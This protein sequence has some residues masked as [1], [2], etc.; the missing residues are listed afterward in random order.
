MLV[1]FL[2][3]RAGLEGPY[4]WFTG[5]ERPVREQPID[6]AVLFNQALDSLFIEYDQELLAQIHPASDGADAWA[7]SFMATLTLEEKIG[8][9]F[10]TNLSSS[11]SDRA[12]RAALEAVQDNKVG[13]FLV[14]RAMDPQ[15]VHEMTTLLQDES[16]VPLF[17]AADY[18]RG[19]GRFS[20]NLTEWPSNMGLGA[21]RDPLFAAAAGRLT[22]IEG[23]AVGVNMVFAP[24]VDVNN[25]PDNPTINIRSYGEDPELVG[26]MAK[27]FVNEAQELG[28]LTTLKHFPGHGNSEVDSHSRMGKIYGDRNSL[29]EIELY[30]YRVVFN[31][32]MNP[33][34]VMTAHLWT[35]AFDEEPLPATFSKNVLNDLL[36]DTLRFDGLII[37]DDVK[38]G[39]L[40][41][42]YSLEERVVNP[43][44]AGADIVLTPRD[45]ERSIEVV[46]D[47]VEDGKV[48]EEMLERSVRR[49]LMAKASSGLHRARSVDKPVLD[50]LLSSPRGERLA[51]KAADKAVTLLQ[52]DDLLPL[53]PNQN[54]ALVQLANIRSSPSID[55]A[56]DLFAD[57]VSDSVEVEEARLGME[58]GDREISDVMDMVEDADAIV[59]AMYLRLRAGRGEAGLYPDQEDVVDQ[60]VAMDKP[61]VLITLGNPYA[62]TPYP[63][64]EALLVAYEQSLAS[65][66]S[67]ANILS[68][69]HEPAG[70]LP[71]TV[72]QFAFGSGLNQTLPPQNLALDDKPRAASSTAMR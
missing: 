69:A 71:I 2:F 30:P 10:I 49:I 68:G 36:R 64:A 57:M 13:G 38:M 17:F 23:R 37:T 19:V 5:E 21:T 34:A 11:T 35:P 67:T 59:V 39:A 63:D 42:D 70:K 9:L 58:P 3:L 26:V 6:P 72:G 54:V 1:A 52:N 46:K 41:N 28:M 48:S 31:E 18:E 50:Y 4:Y 60:L 55:A 56:M 65:V 20:N 22:A 43:L 25:N 16:T 33:T 44:L 66:R 15:D 61:I 24:V 27:M 7:D 47:A 12:R 62:I 29:N 45:L 32:P 53:E 14:S 40:Q 51:Q 8:Q